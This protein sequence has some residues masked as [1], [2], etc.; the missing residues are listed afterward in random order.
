[1]IRSSTC[2]TSNPMHSLG[3]HLRAGGSSPNC[4]TGPSAYAAGVIAGSARPGNRCGARGC[5]PATRGRAARGGAT[6]DRKLRYPH[7][8]SLL[9]HPETSAGSTLQSPV[10]TS[11][12][13]SHRG[14][15]A[16]QLARVVSRRRR[17]NTVQD[18]AGTTRPLSRPLS[19]DHRQAA[20]LRARRHAPAP[21]RKA[22]R[23]ADA[24]NSQ[25]A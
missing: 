6:H 19:H 10:L 11:H 25:A 21:S 15:H 23:T 9:S 1:M 8:P 24:T 13:T 5:K 2:I 18:P 7:D 12:R 16:P 3:W 20:R 4:S 22:A 14:S 17:P